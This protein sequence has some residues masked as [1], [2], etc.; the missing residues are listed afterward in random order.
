MRILISGASGLV[1]NAIIPMLKQAGYEI[2]VLTTQHNSSCFSA[3]VSVQY[4]NPEKGVFDSNVLDNI[5]AI[6]SLAGS[7]I[8]QRWTSKAKKSILDS[9]VL[10][11][12]L[13]VNALMANKKHRV[14]HFISA[15]AIGIYPSSNDKIYSENEHS[16]SKSFPGQVVHAWEAEVNE[17][18]SVI[19]HVS[20]IR[21]GLVLAKEGGALLP[22]ALPTSFG[23]GSW[24]GNGMQWQSWIHIHDLA[25][26]FLFTL[27]HP[28]C[29]NGVAPNPVT[30]KELVKTIAKT[31]GVM[32]W[33]P[34]I[35][36]FFIKI[37]MGNMASIL[38]DS[39][40]ASSEFAES[41]GFEFNYPTLHTAM[42]H[43]FPLRDK[44]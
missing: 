39:I 26:L 22:L 40:K 17:A 8:N 24:F 44:K 31:Y 2:V 36:K 14:S 25:R 27:A 15:S 28:G 16:V 19:K 13:L 33:L 32:Q 29:Y 7:K 6:I 11:T 30:Q 42:R 1:G 10:G 41:Q 9:R 23:F 34:G 43:L 4:W 38:F 12:R 35:P 21:I 20:K 18:V 37:I 5:D 3:D